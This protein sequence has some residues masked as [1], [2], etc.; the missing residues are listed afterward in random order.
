MKKFIR[1]IIRIDEEKCDGCGLC[2][3]ACHEGAIAIVDGKARLISESHCD[4]LGDCLG[5]CPRGAITIERREADAYDEEAVRKAQEKK[6]SEKSLPCGCPGTMARSL[7]EVPLPDLCEEADDRALEKTKDPTLSR[8]ANWPV[9]LALVPVSAPYLKGA[10][11]VLAADCTAFACPDF[12]DRFLEGKILLMGC[13]K[14]DDAASYEEKI[15][16]ILSENGIEK[17]E[18]VFMEVPCCGGLVR[19]VQ[20]AIE[21]AHVSVSLT[22]TKVGIHGAV[23][24]KET[25]LYRFA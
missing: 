15:G 23:L 24:G 6:P 2:A 22:L 21:R 12:H 4:G 11:L 3:T 25:I 1:P 7:K 10:S 9:Q 14:L 19:L 18:V 16:A 8:L 5:E 20:S 13:P 17:V